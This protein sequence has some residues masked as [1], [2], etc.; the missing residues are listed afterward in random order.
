MPFR[1]Q[2]GGGVPAATVSVC[3]AGRDVQP[4]LL[5]CLSLGAPFFFDLCA[6]REGGLVLAVVVVY[7][8]T[9]VANWV[10]LVASQG[11]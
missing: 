1:G 9:G 4:G 8:R 10:F 5:L 2:I 7:F 6:P 11:V 3:L